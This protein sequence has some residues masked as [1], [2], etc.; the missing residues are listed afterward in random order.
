MSASTSH[1][2]HRLLLL[3]TLLLLPLAAL[4]FVPPTSA[5]LTTPATPHPAPA[6]AAAAV[7]TPAA[8]VVETLILP[9]GDDTQ[10]KI[11]FTQESFTA[12]ALQTNQV[13]G[14]GMVW[15]GVVGGWIL[16]GR[17]GGVEEAACCRR[18][19]GSIDP[20]IVWMH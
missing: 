9:M 12:L 19:V 6:L 13:R 14:V 17:V 3:V 2:H 20:W 11:R 16:S 15:Y 7:A 5:R 1:H 10:L 18:V 8:V 4:G